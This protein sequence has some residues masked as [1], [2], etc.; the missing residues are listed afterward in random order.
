[1]KID[2]KDIKV[3][4]RYRKEMGDL[5]PLKKSISEI[6][7]MHPV[8]I[9][10]NDELIAGERRLTALKQLGWKEIPYTRIN[11]K[12]VIRGE[13]DENN[14]RKEFTLSEKVAIDKAMEKLV[15]GRGK[16]L[17]NLDR[18]STRQKS[19]KYLGVSH[20]TLSKAKQII[21]HGTPEMVEQMDKTNKVDSIYKQIKKE[22]QKKE[23]EKLV[24]IK[25]NYDVI[26]ID[27]PWGS[28]IGDYD[29]AGARGV[30]SYPTMDIEQLKKI[31]LPME[32]N[33]VI[34]VWF[35]N[36]M[37]KEVVELTDSWNIE[38][39]TILTWNKEIMGVG[40]FLR[41]IT[42]HC[43]L[44]FRGKPYFSNTKWTTLINEKRTTH[45]TK[46]EIF[47]K[48]VEETCAG[49]KLDY[50]ARKKRTGWD[51]YGDEVK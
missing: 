41:N 49:K 42:E 28:K 30:A 8:V 33:C 20:G 5:E 34:W 21:E 40:H 51:S 19:E 39:K 35:P 36:Y 2:I 17:S 15:G 31:K 44:C 7:L 16:T 11:L 23:I 13:F 43:L 24:P 4:N 1:M 32:E 3:N 46:P 25:K 45:S 18:V 10:E 50:F 26:V 12:E 22:E 37:I 14:V 27:C 47:Y 48:L 29:E 6:G 9:N 38:R